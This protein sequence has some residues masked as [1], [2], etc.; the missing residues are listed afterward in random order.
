M[1]Q[2]WSL[3]KLFI[4]GIVTGITGLGFLTVSLRVT[5]PL[6]SSLVW[7]IS[8]DEGETSALAK[9]KRVGALRLMSSSLEHIANLFL[10]H[11]HLNGSVVVD[12]SSPQKQILTESVKL[13]K[14]NRGDCLSPCLTVSMQK[15][16]GLHLKHLILKEKYYVVLSIAL[17]F[18]DLYL[19]DTLSF[20]LMH[21]SGLWNTKSNK[22]MN[23][24]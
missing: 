16:C 19:S 3:K 8:P 20:S 2:L 7:N 4:L 12:S 15:Y 5:R 10:F 23:W 14:A 21:C 6:L 13:D 9:V 1:S 24:V 18:A 22:I 11:S 17:F